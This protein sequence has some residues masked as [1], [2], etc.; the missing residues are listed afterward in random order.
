M[1]GAGYEQSGDRIQLFSFFQTQIFNFW[2]RRPTGTP[3]LWWT[4]GGQIAYGRSN[5]LVSTRG[6]LDKSVE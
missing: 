4:W 6:N 3:L 2:K 1:T 5:G